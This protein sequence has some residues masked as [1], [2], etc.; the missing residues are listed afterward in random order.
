MAL[1]DGL[2]LYE[3]VLLICGVVFFLGLL[4]TLLW[5]IFANQEYKN[6]LPFFMLPI[7]MIGFPSITSIKVKGE[8]VEIDKTTHDLQSKPQ[9]QQTRAALQT[10][11]AKLGARPLKDPIIL[12]SL[13]NAQFALGDENKAASILKRALA[14]TP[15][16]APAVELKNKIELVNNL[17]AQTAAAESHP[18]DAKASEQLLGT[19]SKLSQVPTANPKLIEALS[20]AE[21]LLQKNAADSH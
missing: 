6:L 13:A 5:K 12:A 9:D 7:V 20:K 3:I 14:A 11:V 18:D 4:V 16:L 8:V 17:R 1:F 2:Y 21:A 19:Y 10:Q 15:N